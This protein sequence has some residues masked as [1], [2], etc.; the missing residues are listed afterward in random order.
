MS[1]FRKTS[2]WISVYEKF[3]YP[4][5]QVVNAH[6]RNERLLV[7]C[8]RVLDFGVLLVSNLAFLTNSLIAHAL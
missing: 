6:M 2:L 7:V 5:V 4:F 1:V 3:I 8:L